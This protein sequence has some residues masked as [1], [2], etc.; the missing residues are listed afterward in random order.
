M[1]NAETGRQGDRGIDRETQTDRQA[2]KQT[3]TGY[4]LILLAAVSLKVVTGSPRLQSSALNT[5]NVRVICSL[6]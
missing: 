3:E 2:G 6:L 5:S 4:T 1:T